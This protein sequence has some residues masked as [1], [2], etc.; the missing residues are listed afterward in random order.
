MQRNCMLKICNV[1]KLDCAFVRTLKRYNFAFMHHTIRNAHHRRRRLASYRMRHLFTLRDTNWCLII[2]S[3]SEILI[4]IGCT[5][6][7][8]VR[9]HD[10]TR[11]DLRDPTYDGLNNAPGV[12]WLSRY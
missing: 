10:R 11:R 8:R 2:D 12:G 7:D 1:A 9:H 4:E 6:L 5:G 3:T